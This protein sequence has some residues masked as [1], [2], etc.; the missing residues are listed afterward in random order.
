MNPPGGLEPRPPARR[1]RMVISRPPP[2]TP[3]QPR[4]SLRLRLARVRKPAGRTIAAAAAVAIGAAAVYSYLHRPPPLG[5]RDTLLLAA[6]AARTADAA[7]D[8]ALGRGLAFQLD[9]SP[10]LNLLTGEFVAD[11][12][13]AM[14]RSPGTPLTPEVAREICRRQGIKGWIEG[15]VAAAG[16]HYNLDLRA[17]NTA[18]GRTLAR[19]Q[20]EAPTRDSVLHALGNAAADLRR[21][22][23]ESPASVRQFNTP[24]P[25]AATS[26]LAALQAS[27]AARRASDAGDYAAAL[28]G[29]R[30]A[31]EL[32]P[33]FAAAWRALSCDAAAA[34]D[35][36]LAAAAATQAYNLRDRAS[37][38]ERL[39]IEG[40]YFER[41]TA[42]WDRAA[43]AWEAAVQ[44][45]P[46][47]YAAWMNLATLSAALGRYD[48]AVR[49][50]RQAVSSQPTSAAYS[51][52]SDSLLA[53]NR[54]P[55]AKEA[56]AQA[57]REQRDSIG[58]HEALYTIAFLEGD[59]AAIGP[60]LEWIAARDP[61]ASLALERDTAAAL[62]R[63]RRSQ[64]IS[65]RIVDSRRTDRFADSARAAIWGRCQDA[66]SGPAT[67]SALMHTALA[68]AACGDTARTLAI[69][70]RLGM[71]Y[72]AG[73]GI[74]TAWVPCMNA[75]ASAVR[76]RPGLP[77]VDL[78]VANPFGGAFAL[79]LDY[80]R[81]QV[82]LA[83]RHP[84]EAA[85]QFQ[86]VLDRRAWAPLTPYYASAQLGLA[87]VAVQ[88]ASLSRARQLYQDFFALMKDADP[89]LPLL[90]AARREYEKLQ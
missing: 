10:Y 7:F 11:S 29:D 71:H 25:Q 58:C 46:R 5:P 32:D 21:R 89:D 42:Q 52:L 38:L 60:H 62:G 77:R 37:A 56:C 69:A 13:R 23:G 59:P 63:L 74:D 49:A 82:Y 35:P 8:D 83:S 40:A 14:G 28:A 17:V 1:R 36:D 15:A 79:A 47:R 81:G 72:P 75:L 65:R 90:A 70:G 4:A 55:E 88:S 33:G 9:Q 45:Y 67:Q 27:S 85:V 6:F 48:R 86:R 16:G 61:T 22:L 44:L 43:D 18:T 19:A 30:R 87:R 50:A 41:V 78:Q 54:F 84:A 3:P 64:E 73:T 51:S 66:D 2:S 39:N 53:Q 31:V 12:L 26:S 34:G 80:C 24:L 76:G 20:A 68:Y 57:A